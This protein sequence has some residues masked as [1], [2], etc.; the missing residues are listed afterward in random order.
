MSMCENLHESARE[1]VTRL[2]MTEMN[3]QTYFDAFKVNVEEG[4][5]QKLR[6]LTEAASLR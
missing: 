4:F 6:A 2:S 1:T 5:H 3:C